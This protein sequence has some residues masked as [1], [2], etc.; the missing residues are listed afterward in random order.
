M[1]EVFLRDNNNE[2]NSL[3][4]DMNF[5]NGSF[6][7]IIDCVCSYRIELGQLLGKLIE[8]YNSVFLQQYQVFYTGK[9][10]KERDL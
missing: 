10:K 3:F 1:K 2:H 8:S 5:L 7:D 4:R 9:L 6:T